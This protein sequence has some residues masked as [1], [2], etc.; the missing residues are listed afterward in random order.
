MEPESQSTEQKIDTLR[1]QISDL[2]S[3]VEK[4][5]SQIRAPEQIANDIAMQIALGEMVRFALG[6]IAFDQDVDTSKQRLRLFEQKI[7]ANLTSR[8][9][10]S[11]ADDFTETTIK[12]LASGYITRTI[13]SIR[14]PDDD[15]HSTLQR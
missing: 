15:Q 7:I 14:H 12:E 9:I 1:M 5:K 11:K 8:R 3:Q 13:T 4:L 10:F 6:E 2:T